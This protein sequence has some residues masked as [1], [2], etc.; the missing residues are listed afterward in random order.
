VGSLSEN[1]AKVR[2]LYEEIWECRFPKRQTV[3]EDLLALQVLAPDMAED[4]H[5]LFKEAVTDT[6]ASILG[7]NEARSLMRQLARTDFESPYSVFEELDSILHGGS[8]VLRDAIVEEFRVNV[9]LLLEKTER[10]VTRFID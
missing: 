1:I 7:Q 4:L 5:C 2:T 9:R 10:K 3:E 8:K 6:L